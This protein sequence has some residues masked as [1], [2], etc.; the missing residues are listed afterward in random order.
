MKSGFWQIRINRYKITFTVFFRHYERKDMSFELKNAL[1]E[2]RNIMNNI[3]THFTN[4]SIN[5]VLIFSKSIKQNWKHLHAFVQII[6]NNGLIISLT[7]INLSLNNIHFLGHNIIQNIFINKSLQILDKIKDK[8]QLQ[9]FL[10]SLN[11]ISDYYKN[12]KIICKS[13]YQKLKKNSPLW[14]NQY[15]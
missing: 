14:S 15:T 6:K 3:F 11:Y 13:H 2:F 9:R 5:D 1:R 7:K 12:F 4:F 10:E 8:N